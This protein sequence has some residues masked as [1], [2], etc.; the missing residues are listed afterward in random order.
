MF[1]KDFGEGRL[2]DIDVVGSDIAP[3][4]A[5]R[6]ERGVGVITVVVIDPVNAYCL[7]SKIIPTSSRHASSPK[8]LQSIRAR[9]PSIRAYT[10]SFTFASF[11]FDSILLTTAG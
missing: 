4:V 7:A 2:Y 8:S 11:V 3:A 1:A 6:S 10:H 5:E 9:S